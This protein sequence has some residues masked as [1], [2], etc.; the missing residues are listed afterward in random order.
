MPS[1]CIDHGCSKCC[2]D[3]KMPLSE[4]DV[5]R[6]SAATGSAVEEFTKPLAET[7]GVLELAN[8]SATDACVF[9]ETDSRELNAPGICVIHEIRP[10]GC[11]SYP[12][13]L[14]MEDLVFKDDLCP[15]KDEFEEPTENHRA[16]LLRLDS[17]IRSEAAS[18]VQGDAQDLHELE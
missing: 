4:E 11:R 14:D 16:E 5:L 9:L 6:I 17:Q 13:V 12:I 8:S 10:A 3:T 2:R 1:P 15:W 18:R 7:R